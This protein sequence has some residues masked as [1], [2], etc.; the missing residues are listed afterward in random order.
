MHNG[1]AFKLL[2]ELINGG[3]CSLVYA[4]NTDGLCNYMIGGRP[5]ASSAGWH[6]YSMRNSNVHRRC[7]GRP[8]TQAWWEVKCAALWKRHVCPGPQDWS[9]GSSRPTRSDSGT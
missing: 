1:A 5:L 4:G 7:L 9:Y 8:C 3:A 6:S 2:P